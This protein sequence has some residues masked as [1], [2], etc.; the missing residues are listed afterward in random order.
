MG[1]SRWC[2]ELA[3][4]WRSVSHSFIPP[5]VLFALGIESTAVER[6]SGRSS[7][8]GRAQ[9]VYLGV[10]HRLVR[11]FSFSGLFRCTCVLSRLVTEHSC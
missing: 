3:M 7:R 9:I 8:G 10:R 2:L 11:V 4:G 1:K 5:G 6:T